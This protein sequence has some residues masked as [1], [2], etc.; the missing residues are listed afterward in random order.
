MNCNDQPSHHSMRN[1]F[2]FKLDS[3]TWQI[4]IPGGS[5]IEDSAAFFARI[6][7]IGNQ[8]HESF[9]RQ[10]KLFVYNPG[11]LADSFRRLLKLSIGHTHPGSMD[12]ISKQ[13]YESYRHSLRRNPELQLVDS[14]Q[15]W[16]TIDRQLFQVE[17]YRVRRGAD[18][19]VIRE[20]H[21]P[22]REQ[23]LIANLIYYESDTL[24]TPLQNALEQSTFDD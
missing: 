13:R 2:R 20:Y 15:F 22:R 4:T 21:G 11:A 3:G 10:V 12:L 6:D 1:S 5:I 23:M 24:G 17:Q 9:L 7:T 16:M 19:V 8:E 14:S 18:Y